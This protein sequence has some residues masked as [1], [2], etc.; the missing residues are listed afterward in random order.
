MET[1]TL[2]RADIFLDASR[3]FVPQADDN[4]DCIPFYRAWAGMRAVLGKETM[5][6]WHHMFHEAICWN[7]PKAETEQY[8][9]ILSHAR[10][11]I[12]RWQKPEVPRT[13]YSWECA[14]SEPTEQDAR[15]CFSSEY[16]VAFPKNRLNSKHARELWDTHKD[17][18]MQLVRET[19]QANLA[20]YEKREQDR[21]ARADRERAEWI[22]KFWS[23]AEFE[24]LVRSLAE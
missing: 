4:P 24:D 12:E 3:A 13:S 17:K 2:T 16:K 7:L 19:Y 21:Q 22:D 20:A 6:N 1:Q 18:A 8:A 10:Y 23:M 5:D 14:P 15:T 9:A 11:M